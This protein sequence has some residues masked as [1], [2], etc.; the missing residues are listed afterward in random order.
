[1]SSRPLDPELWERARSL[2]GEALSLSAGERD[3]WLEQ[4]AGE[5]PQLL[6][7]VRS[8][9]ERT[10]DDSV[11]RGAAGE[12]RDGTTAPRDS[13]APGSVADPSDA[14]GLPPGMPAHIA[15]YRVLSVLGEGGMGWV[16]KARQQNPDRT[17]ALKVIKAGLAGADMKR[18][19]ER[20]SKLLGR[21][22]HPAVAQVY[23]AGTT[24]LGAGV[25]V[26]YFAMELVEQGLPITRYA[27]EHQLDI[28][29]RLE[30][31]AVVAD[32]IDHGHQRGVMHRDIKPM[33]VLVDGT[34]RPRIIDFG[35]C[36]AMDEG[37]DAVS[38]QTATGQIMGTPQ[39]M[40]PEQFE[41]DP[42][43]V[44]LLADVYSLGVL[45]FQ[46]LSFELPYD[47]EGKSLVEV[48]AT[49]RR[50]NP[51]RLASTS[52]GSSGSMRSAADLDTIIAKAMDKVPDRRY[53]SAAAL[54]ADVRRCLRGEPID[55]RPAS[56]LY[57]LRLFTRRNRALVGGVLATV[58]ALTIGLIFTTL[59]AFRANELAE[60]TQRQAYVARVSAAAALIDT[61]P[62]LARIQLEEAPEALRSWEWRHLDS[63]F[64][65]SVRTYEA[66]VPATGPIAI[67]RAGTQLV[68]AL[69]DGRLA[70]W[71]TE[72][73]ELV[74]VGTEL[75]GA[76]IYTLAVPSDGPP[77]IACGT[78]DGQVRVWDLDADR[79]LDVSTQDGQ[80]H[81]L[82]WDRTGARLLFSTE[83]GVHFWRQGLPIRDH[84]IE[85]I[86]GADLPRRIGFRPDG[87]WYT[88]STATPRAGDKYWWDTESGE[89]LS[90]PP[91][92]LERQDGSKVRTYVS[93]GGSWVPIG[94][95]VRSHDTT[96]L[97]IPGGD[98]PR[99]CVLMDAHAPDVQRVLRGHND[100]VV[101]VAWTPDDTR[102]I[103]S[104]D[105]ETIRLWD[106]STGA[107]L[108]AIDADR[109]S[110]FVVTPDG[111]GVVFREEGTLRYWDFSLASTMVVDPDVSYVY[112]LAYSEDGTSLAATSPF[113]MNA[114]LIDPLIGRIAR[115]IDVRA[116]WPPLQPKEVPPPGR[117]PFGLAFSRDGTRLDVG[118]AI[119]DLATDEVV[120]R[121]PEEWIEER[122]RRDR[123]GARFRPAT[124]RSV[125]GTLL[126][127]MPG[128]HNAG[129][130]VIHDVTTG[131]TFLEM[132]GPVWGVAF[133]P[134][135][136]LLATAYENP[137]RVEIWSL[138]EKRKLVELPAHGRITM[139]VDFHP[140]GTRLASGGND[141][142]VVLWDTTT[143]EPV[144]ELRGHSSYVKTVVFSPDGTQ[145][146]SGS[147]DLTAM[148]WDTLP[149]AER[150]RQAMA[151]RGR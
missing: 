149:R 135:G 114:T 39:Y 62:N 128:S 86:D 107:S 38:M 83:G 134:D 139:C 109:A 122:M 12:G 77:L 126:A 54:A 33:N 24:T 11:A 106:T 108:A 53:P 81:E 66:D 69:V 103:T 140:D 127:E 70:I 120:P 32:G 118:S 20:E 41:G 45:M 64:E 91:M 67:I 19:F 104:S 116:G 31:F 131:G 112:H 43:G 90:T 68:S 52:H 141:N 4:Q 17:V 60:A 37:G 74:R 96:R 55:A 34:G 49:V 87:A 56:A 98:G 95:H 42:K 23:E 14:G 97:A 89:R 137:G 80:I 79:W 117:V 26:P 50:E 92:E 124:V 119:I 25:E 3:A 65:R 101:S 73:A 10:A 7:E 63:R 132:E 51:K 143:W 46:L 5:D 148:I 100:Y 84:L 58:V 121:Q 15:S 88:A 125:D 75:V 13:D 99:S 9:L 8:L 82:A 18:R 1:M 146:A 71:D 47:M 2:F 105:D 40:S 48:A 113:S 151:A 142:T 22:H 136:A 29:Q 59:F 110:P 111:S 44:T 129:N 16:F 85:P 72:S 150:H 21:L 78:M 102:L 27:F 138:A 57:Q 61:A 36:R 130:L 144:L 145:L 76:E 94:K 147:G 123:W 6:A 93:P 115:T 133:S 35:L 28:E 30:L